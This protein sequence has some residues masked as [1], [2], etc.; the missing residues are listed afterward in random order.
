MTPNCRGSQGLH[1]SPAF[2][3]FAGPVYENTAIYDKI[4]KA[5]GL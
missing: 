1:P 3:W 4:K 2:F 5:L